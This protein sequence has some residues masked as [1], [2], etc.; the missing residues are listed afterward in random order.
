MLNSIKPEWNSSRLEKRIFKQFDELLENIS[1]AAA[2]ILFLTR[3]DGTK[4]KESA[5]GYFLF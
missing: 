5:V 3:I 1:N 4:V 2:G